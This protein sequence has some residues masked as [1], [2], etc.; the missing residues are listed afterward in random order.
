LNSRTSRRKASVS[1]GLATGVPVGLRGHATDESAPELL[2]ARGGRRR[3]Q[4]GQGTE[5]GATLVVVQ[6][7]LGQDG[8]GRPLQRGKEVGIDHDPTDELDE[9][10]RHDR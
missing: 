6:L 9:T 10:L 8:L 3:S 2:G 4:P 7:V 5:D 1:A